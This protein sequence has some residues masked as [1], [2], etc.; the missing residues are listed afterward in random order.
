MKKRKDTLNGA[1]G[2]EK[3]KKHFPGLQVVKIVCQE[4]FLPGRNL[5]EAK[6]NSV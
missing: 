5:R 3:E 1:G 2:V 4:S 6:K